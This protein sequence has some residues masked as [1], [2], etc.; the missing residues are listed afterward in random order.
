MNDDENEKERARSISSFP[1]WTISPSP[2]QATPPGPS[3]APRL[4]AGP[5]E[6]WTIREK[7]CLA[8]AVR[9]NGDQNWASASRSMRPFLDAHRP[10]DRFSPKNAALQ[11]AA[12]L[13]GG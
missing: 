7:L 5:L 13:E 10:A 6:P 4:Q 9:H 12:L 11:Y 3:S 2:F 8:S 1:L